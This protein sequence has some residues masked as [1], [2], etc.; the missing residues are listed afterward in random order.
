MTPNDPSL[1]RGFPVGWLLALFV[2]ASIRESFEG[3]LLEEAGAEPT[4]KL[5]RARV[6]RTV[7]RSLPGLLRHPGHRTRDNTRSAWTTLPFLLLS[8]TGVAVACNGAAAPPEA[9]ALFFVALAWLSIGLFFATNG[10]R[11][12]L[13]FLGTGTL[14]VSQFLAGP[15]I[16]DSIFLVYMMPGTLY[17][18]LI[19][20][21]EEKHH[22]S[23][24]TGA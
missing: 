13:L 21:T 12:L 16:A 14:L 17:P 1:L 22:C 23:T 18:S 19:A 10:P 6:R 9:I 5:A 15:V 2:P 4:K 20:R 24:R 7:V 8:T 11:L 3:D